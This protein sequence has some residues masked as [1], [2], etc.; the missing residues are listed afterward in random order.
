VLSAKLEDVYWKLVELDGEPVDT[1]ACPQ[2]PHLLF[3]SEDSRLAGSGGCNRLTG[4]YETTGEKLRFQPIAMTRMACEQRVMELE[5]GVAAAL[6]ATN[7]Y[8]IE[9]DELALCD[10]ERVLARLRTTG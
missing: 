3:L 8:G 6:G 7:R 5:H 2:E 4:T 1:A 10:G 9:D